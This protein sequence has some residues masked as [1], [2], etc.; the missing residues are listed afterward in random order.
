MIKLLVKAAAE[1]DNAG[2]HVEADLVDKIMQKVAGGNE[3]D[4][5]FLPKGK[6]STPKASPSK[7]KEEEEEDDISEGEDVEDEEEMEEDV[8]EEMEEEE[9]DDESYELPGEEDMEEEEE[10]DESYDVDED[11]PETSSADKCLESCLQLSDE[12]KVELIKALLD[13]L[14]SSQ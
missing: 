12:E 8:E 2:L 6:T 3:P 11:E 13:S 9:E 4:Y 10:E 7:P 1:L 5:G 14:V